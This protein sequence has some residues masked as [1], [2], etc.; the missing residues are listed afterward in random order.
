VKLRKEYGEFAR[1]FL[2][3]GCA[4]NNAAGRQEWVI[5]TAWNYLV[6]H[7]LRLFLVQ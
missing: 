5:K 3:G 2:S 4:L 1:K 6:S 7:L